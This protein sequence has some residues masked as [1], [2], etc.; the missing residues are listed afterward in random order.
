MLKERQLMPRR[1]D[2]AE[3]QACQPANWCFFCCCSSSSEDPKLAEL[4][5]VVVM[6]ER[7]ASNAN[8]D[9]SRF[10]TRRTHSLHILSPGHLHAGG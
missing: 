9:L 8:R 3:M 4:V 6:M 5:P 10:F 1:S 2:G 7:M